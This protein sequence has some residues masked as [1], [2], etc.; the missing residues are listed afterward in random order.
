[1]NSEDAITWS[2]FGPFLAESPSSRADF[3]NWL[4]EHVGLGDYATSEV[5]EIDLWRRIPH[6][7]PPFVP[8]GPELDVVLDGDAAVVFCEAKWRSKED[9]KQGR[10]GTKTQMQLRRDF[11]GTIGPRVYGDRA[12][13]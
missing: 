1:M 10:S 12:F 11:L 3:L 5:C 2:Y 13:V 4:L 8:G 9:T 7:D 6:P